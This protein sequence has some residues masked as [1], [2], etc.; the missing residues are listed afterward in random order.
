MRRGRAVAVAFGVVALLL[1]PVIRAMPVGWLRSYSLSTGV[2]LL[3][4]S[5]VVP[6]LL[7]PLAY[8]AMFRATCWPPPASFAPGRY[9]G[10][11]AL[12][13]PYNP[14]IVGPLYIVQLT[15][16]G[17]AIPVGHDVLDDP[18]L[19][20]ALVLCATL[21]A[22]VATIATAM[23]LRPPLLRLTSTAVVLTTALSTSTVTWDDLA[24]G[25]PTSTEVRGRALWLQVR[26]DA[27]SLGRPRAGGPGGRPPTPG[28]RWHRIALGGV[29]IDPHFLADTLRRF[30]DE[31]AIRAEMP[32]NA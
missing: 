9:R 29:L 7:L 20:T 12:A 30:R 2:G 24:P 22:L 4:L 21:A 6:A 31:P 25:G 3:F 11:P 18:M 5:I 32:V 17:L 27:R 28:Y 16:A 8:V 1:A 26:D 13:A 15:S 14:L 19:T 10:E 23:L